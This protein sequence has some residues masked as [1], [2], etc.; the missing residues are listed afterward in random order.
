MATKA[1]VNK[2]RSVRRTPEK[3]RW[4]NDCTDWVKHVPWHFHKGHPEAYGEIPE[5]KIEETRTGAVRPVDDMESPLVVV[6]TR[7]VPPRA[8]QTRKEDVEVHWYTKGCAGCSKWFFGLGRQP[9]TS[10]CR[11]RFAQIMKEDARYQNA[12]KR[13]QEFEDK[14]RE[15]KALSISVA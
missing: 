11:A 6:R 7:Q 15:K 14:M 1:G 8:F 3:D 10:E 13:K 4:S 12:E 2:A 9:H 5:E